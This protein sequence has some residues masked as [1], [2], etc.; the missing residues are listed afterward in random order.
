LET[1]VVIFDF[2]KN[3]L[4]IPDSILLERINAFEKL[5][6]AYSVPLVEYYLSD[7]NSIIGVKGKREEP[8][9]IL[10]KDCSTKTPDRVIDQ[11]ETYR[12]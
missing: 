8:F 2:K 11:K 7:G 12:A 1:G 10:E 4:L 5:L 6:N 9:S 3:R